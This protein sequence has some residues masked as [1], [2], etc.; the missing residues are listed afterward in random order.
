MTKLRSDRAGIESRR[1]GFRASAGD[2]SGHSGAIHWPGALST[3]QAGPHVLPASYGKKPSQ[4]GLHALPA[5]YGKKTS[6]LVSTCC[7][8]LMGRSVAL[9]LPGKIKTGTVPQSL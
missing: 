6:G 7:P 9:L 5:S 3:L 2:S 8:L 1:C 4:A